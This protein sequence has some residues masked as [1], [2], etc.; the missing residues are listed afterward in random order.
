MQLYE[1]CPAKGTKKVRRI[2]GR[3]N[4]SGRG[5]TSGRGQKGQ[6]ARSGRGIINSL[7]GGQ[8]PLIRRLPKIGFR[9]K[10]PV[11][12][13]VVSLVDL[14][15]FASGTN[16]DASVLK[17]Q[18]LIRNIYKPYKILG[19]GILKNAVT[20]E[21]YGFSQSAGDKIKQAGGTIKII[22]ARDVKK[23]QEQGAK[24]KQGR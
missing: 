21:A 12:Y 13:Q 10:S 5:K 19:N 14:G 23:A 16:I 18:G 4:G 3:G 24:T 15:R 17:A 11:F 9:S 22:T 2:V 20:V 7:H 6:S 8:M 1:L